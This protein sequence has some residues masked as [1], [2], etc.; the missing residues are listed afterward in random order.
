MLLNQERCPAWWG[1]VRRQVVSF[2]A[3]GEKVDEPC[4]AMSFRRTFLASGLLLCY[5][6]L[7]K[8][9]RLHPPLPLHHGRQNA[10]DA[11]D[12]HPQ[13]LLKWPTKI[14][15]MWA[16]QRQGSEGE[17]PVQ[18]SQGSLATSTLSYRSSTL[19]GSWVL[20]FQHHRHGWGTLV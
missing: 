12:P 1:S 16:L 3:S 6:R 19:A 13:F 17:A 7:L 4:T 9:E 14:I 20:N 8:S 15:D 10:K 2:F 18:Q 5:R 11:G